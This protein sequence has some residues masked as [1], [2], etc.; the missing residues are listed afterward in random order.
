VG[1]QTTAA[2]TTVTLPALSDI[3]KIRFCG[4]ET[5][6][7]KIDDLYLLNSSGTSLNTWLGPTT[8]VFSPALVSTNSTVTDAPTQE[9]SSVGSLSLSSHDPDSDYLTTKAVN[10]T[11]LYVLDSSD[12]VFSIGEYD[13]VA[14][15]Q[16]RSTARETSLPAA[17]S[18]IFNPATEG[19][20]SALTGATEIQTQSYYQTKTTILATNPSTSS[21]WALADLNAAHFGIKSV[22]R[23]GV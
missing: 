9:W 14:A 8:R 10:K 13:T 2:A 7:V 5:Q 22:T 6:E 1:R 12:G 19:S 21:A 16:L 18:Q 3:A 20:V 4:N 23:T 11:Q 15:V 17:Y